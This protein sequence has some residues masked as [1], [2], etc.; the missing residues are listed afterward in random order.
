MATS[1]QFH[2]PEP[3]TGAGGALVD[4]KFFVYQ[5]LLESF[6]GGPPYPQASHIEVFATRSTKWS[7]VPTTGQHPTS[8]WG[9]ACV[10]IG[11]RIYYYGGRD[12]KSYS[13]ALHEFDTIC[14]NWKALVSANP[15]SAPMAK[16]YSAM[17]AIDNDTLCTIGGVGLPSGRLPPGAAFVPL[18]SD[19]SGQTNELHLYSMKSGIH[20]VRTSKLP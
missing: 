9:F 18:L 17:I 1:L 4:D 11:H 8:L 10:A 6:T 15:R 13:N 5:G 12:G 3:R 7:K 2:E 16:A 19:G 14:D 20:L